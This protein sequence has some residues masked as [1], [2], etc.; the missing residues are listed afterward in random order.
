M[1]GRLVS[2]SHS[3]SVDALAAGN[4]AT[5]A[6]PYAEED[7]DYEPDF[8]TET[9]EQVLNDLDQ[10]S[11]GDDPAALQPPEVAL[12]PFNLPP[13]PRLSQ[14]QAIDYSKGA[15]RR[16]F[17]TLSA[18]DQ[19][20]PAKVVKKG[21]NRLAASNH[22]RDAWI[23]IV[24]RLA[25][26]TTAGLEHGSSEEKVNGQK[27]LANPSF[28]VSDAIRDALYMYVIDDFRRRIDVA[29]TWLNEEWYTARVQSSE[30]SASDMMTN[31]NSDHLTVYTRQLHRVLDGFLPFLDARDNRLLIRFLS[32]IPSLDADVVRKITRLASDP[33]RVSLAVSAIHYL[34]LL[35]PPVRALC[36]DAA[37]DLYRHC[38]FPERSHFQRHQA[39]IE[40]VIANI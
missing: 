14:E 25:T 37:V 35:R 38:K 1:R 30:H 16:V 5:G 17:G 31:G 2:L 23:T 9:T 39:C 6:D 11:S 7:E 20:P 22:D 29:I 24:T 36:I 28:S 40:I 19:L 10:T 33:E 15:V 13:P 27:A 18:L 12:G 4:A 32:E 3:Q 26:R 8:P 21:F 34:I